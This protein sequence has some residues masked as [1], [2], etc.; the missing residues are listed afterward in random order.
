MPVGEMKIYSTYGGTVA[1]NG[2]LPL[3]VLAKLSS[4]QLGELAEA[5]YKYLK[6]PTHQLTVCGYAY[7]Y[8][9]RKTPV[10]RLD[11]L[12]KTKNARFEQIDIK[13]ERPDH[14]GHFHI[15]K[16]V[17]KRISFGYSYSVPL[18]GAGFVGYKEKRPV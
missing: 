16:E 1:G 6:T 3:S 8:L 13:G 4:G 5:P 15:A 11:S 18:G 2:N 12:T 9:Y 14:A 7:N 17:L 10:F